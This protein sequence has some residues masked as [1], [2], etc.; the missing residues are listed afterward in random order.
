M[1]SLG[2]IRT[3]SKVD[4]IHGKRMLGWLKRYDESIT[5]NNINND[6]GDS[7]VFCKWLF[8]NVFSHV[9]PGS[10]RSYLTTVRKV[11]DCDTL[12]SEISTFAK[13]SS[14]LTNK[15]RPKS[16]SISWQH[17]AVL[18]SFLISRTTHTHDEAA[19]WLR[20][21]V[22]T[23]LRPSEWS[24]SHLFYGA[25]GKLSIRATNTLKAELAPDGDT[26][27][28]NKYRII[29]LIQLDKADLACVRRH[30]E[31]AHLKVAL[32]QFEEWYNT[33]R[34]RLYHASKQCFPLQPTFNLYSG[35]HQFCANLKSA[36]YDS[37]IIMYL[38]GHNNTKTSR[39][40]YGAKRDGNMK[41][42]DTSA[43]EKQVQDFQNVFG[44]L[45]D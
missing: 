30:V 22:I 43:T 2:N 5:S 17:F 7:K 15:K 35:R 9:R 37:K 31:V 40:S 41:G 44:D 24:D 28:L 26:Y 29:P 4:D 19:D 34:L 25:D 14:S 18:E 23:G 1:I 8:D 42:I 12:M 21:T 3:K 10:Q 32:G 20:A 13:V 6:E 33:S 27:Q 16:K 38:M 39:H 11:T 36:G 45:E